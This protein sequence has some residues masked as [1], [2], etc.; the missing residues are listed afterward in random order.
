MYIDAGW[1]HA[2]LTQVKTEDVDG[3][4]AVQLVW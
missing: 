2:L 4:N 3:Y 1:D